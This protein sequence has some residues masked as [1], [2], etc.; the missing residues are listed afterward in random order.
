MLDADRCAQM[1][2]GPQPTADLAALID[3]TNWL[4]A[5]DL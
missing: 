2:C 4:Q 5:I 3:L 1:T